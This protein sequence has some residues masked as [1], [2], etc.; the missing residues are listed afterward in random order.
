LVAPTGACAERII[1][2]VPI[3][4]PELETLPRPE[5]ERLQ[6]ERLRERFGVELEALPSSRSE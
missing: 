4:Q 6:G 5:L 2:A 3:F 1:R